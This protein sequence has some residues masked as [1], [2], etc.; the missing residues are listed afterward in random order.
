[1]NHNLAQKWLIQFLQS[2]AVL[3]IDLKEPHSTSIILKQTELKFYLLHLVKFT[4]DSNQNVDRFG[5]WS[6]MS[7]NGV[8]L[9][10]KHS[11]QFM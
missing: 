7:L 9:I 6:A 5:N 2:P 10:V 1:M 8:F 11:Q 3:H 4:S